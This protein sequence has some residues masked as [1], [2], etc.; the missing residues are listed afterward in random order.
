MKMWI[1][2][3]MTLIVA[4][5]VTAERATAQRP[6]M[7]DMDTFPRPIAAA[8]NVWIIVHDYRRDVIVVVEP[9]GILCLT[10]AEDFPLVL[11]D[12]S[13]VVVLGNVSDQ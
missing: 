9:V 12:I 5:I 8:D 4:F 2:A 1:R 7:K 10:D 11:Q 13:V 3:G 6:E